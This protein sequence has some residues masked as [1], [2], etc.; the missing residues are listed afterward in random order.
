MSSLETSKTRGQFDEGS[1]RK[2]EV[3]WT[4]GYDDERYGL[5]A[6]VNHNQWVC[7]LP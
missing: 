1:T 3:I 2:G 6:V 5:G 4:F 7:R